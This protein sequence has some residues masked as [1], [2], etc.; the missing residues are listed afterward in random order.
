MPAIEFIKVISESG[1]VTTVPR[2]Q[3]RVLS[4]KGWREAT[5]EEV[6]AAAENKGVVT[7]PA[8]VDDDLDEVTEPAGGSS[9]PTVSEED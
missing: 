5:P 9:W 7:E 1:R 6:A 3:M 2:P 8:G 4:A